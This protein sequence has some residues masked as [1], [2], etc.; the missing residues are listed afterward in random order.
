MWKWN[1]YGTSLFTCHI[2]ADEELDLNETVLPPM[3]IQPFIENAIWHGTS[4]LQKGVTINVHFKK[5]DNQLVCTIEDDGMGIVKSLKNKESA[6]HLHHSVGITNIKNRIQLL[7]EKYNLQCNIVIE[8]KSVLTG[9]IETGTLVTL[10]L[11]I[12]LNV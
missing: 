9:S 2:S 5:E 3:L 8:D 7:N 1:K 6:T 11:P 4:N 10:K 12:D